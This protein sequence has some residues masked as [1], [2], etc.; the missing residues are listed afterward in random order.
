MQLKHTLKSKLT[1]GIQALSFSPTGNSVAAVAVDP[2]HSVAVFNVETGTQIAMEK[3][4]VGQILDISMKDD[5]TF[6]TSGIKHFKEWTVG[7]GN[8]TSVVGRFGKF[9]NRHGVC[10]Y[11]GQQCVSGSITGELYVWN[12]GSLVNAI[13]LHE[14]PIDAIH[15]SANQVFTGGKDLKV[16]VLNK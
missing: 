4:D 5:T 7:T 8:L 15:V 16:S 13:K 11:A 14:K 9:D 3:G 1:K 10:K 12:G 6:A 2:D